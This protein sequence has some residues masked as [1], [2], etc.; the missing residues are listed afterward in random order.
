MDEKHQEDLFKML[1]H[2]AAGID[3]IAAALTV[4]VSEK[5]KDE[6]IGSSEISTDTQAELITMETV[7]NSALKVLARAFHKR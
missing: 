5:L 6:V 3:R 4:Q 7:R 2:I 1:R